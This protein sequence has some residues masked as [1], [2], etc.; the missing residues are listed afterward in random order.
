MGRLSSVYIS[1]FGGVT[2]EWCV[3]QRRVGSPMP[4]AR[5]PWEI[6]DEPCFKNP[7]L[8]GFLPEAGESLA[9]LRVAPGFSWESTLTMR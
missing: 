5:V 9:T 7:V 4:L 3:T 8:G 6:L 1:P 2:K